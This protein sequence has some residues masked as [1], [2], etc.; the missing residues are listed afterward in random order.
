MNREEIK[1]SEVLIGDI[2]KLDHLATKYAK[3]QQEHPLQ[4]RLEQI[5]DEVLTEKELEL[6]LLRFGEQLPFR[7]IAKRLGYA[8]HR[9]FQLQINTI[10][11]KVE[12]ALGRTDIRNT[13][14][15]G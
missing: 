8:S 5:I 1:P 13:T 7:Q 6:Y 11:K 9:T 14:G 3:K 2:K 10:L 15:S 4:R 12:E